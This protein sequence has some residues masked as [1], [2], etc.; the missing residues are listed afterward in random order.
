MPKT[1]LKQEAYQHI[2]GKITSCEYAPGMD[3]TEAFL[4]EDTGLSR[5]PIRDALSR[6]EQ[7]GLLLIMPKK[8]MRVSDLTVGDINA[9]YET[10]NLV[11][12]YAI[13]QFGPKMDQKILLAMQKEFKTLFE[14]EKNRAGNTSGIDL[15][16]LYEVDDNLHQYIITCSANPYLLTLMNMIA[17][18]NARLR[19]LTSTTH[20]RLIASHP[21]HIRILDLLLQEDYEAAAKAMEEHLINF[22]EACFRAIIKNGGWAVS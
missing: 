17:T 18:Q 13:R 3:L 5:T 9:V 11:E 22:K 16:P 6:L 12:P 2:K 14:T 15:A 21:E 19:I 20:A 8:G 10:R 1:P 4:L 7:E